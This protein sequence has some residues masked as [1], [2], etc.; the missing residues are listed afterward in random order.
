MKRQFF[1]E[2][3]IKN[4]IIIFLL[5]ILYL[6]FKNFFQQFPIDSYSNILTV[7]AIL[8]AAAVFAD[9]AFSYVDK[10]VNKKAIRFFG[11]AITFIIMFCTGI[12]LEVTVIIINLEFNDFVWPLTLVAIL[13]Y[14][15]LVLYD[16][17]D[18]LKERK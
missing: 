8:I 6:P 16:F 7:T 9:Y 5:L 13:Y 12:L 4:L 10:F 11:H 14:L 2:N 17:W 18:F 3:L 15:S 1:I